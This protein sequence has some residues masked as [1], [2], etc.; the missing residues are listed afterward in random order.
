VRCT[1][2]GAGSAVTSDSNQRLP[3]SDLHTHRVKVYYEDTDLSG[4]V[5]H[6]NYLKFF[7]RARE[8]FI[9]P[10]VLA[11]LWE[12]RGIGFVVYEANLTFKKSAGLADDLEVRT[13][14]ERQSDYRALFEQTVH[15]VGQDSALVEGDIDIV[16]V[17]ESGDLVELPG[18][19][20]WS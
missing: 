8:H 20:D 4:A 5:Y 14:A 1:D 18:V 12:D 15:H 17:G 6:A 10:E 13:R 11:S 9:G 7:E 3:M 16:C 19:I 2:P